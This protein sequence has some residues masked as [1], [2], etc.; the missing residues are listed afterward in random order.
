VH[1]GRLTAPTAQ[2]LPPSVTVSRLPAVLRILFFALPVSACIHA[3]PGELAGTWTY[4][5]VGAARARWDSA[6]FFSDGTGRLAHSELQQRP[7]SVGKRVLTPADYVAINQS[8]DIQWKVSHSPDGQA[9]LCLSQTTGQE[10]SPISATDSTLAL[11]VSPLDA[12]VYRRSS[13]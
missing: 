7:G 3:L 10:C 1:S 12:A 9:Q 2:Q 11:G 4:E 8:R 6:V 13:P 5:D